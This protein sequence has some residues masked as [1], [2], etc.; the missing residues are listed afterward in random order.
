MDSRVGHLHESFLCWSVYVSAECTI[1]NLFCPE[2][3][4]PD[5]YIF[6]PRLLAP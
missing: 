3:L 5:Y 6:Y 1:L 4:L 2:P